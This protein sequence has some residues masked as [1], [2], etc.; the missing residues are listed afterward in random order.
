QFK[1]A[2]IQNLQ[3]KIKNAQTIGSVR[4]FSVR[5]EFPSEWAKFQ[6]VSIGGT[7][8][9]APLLLTLLPEHYP[10]WAKNI[11]GSKP[12]KE[13]GLFAELDDGK[14]TV[15]LYDKPDPTAS[16]VKTDTL[17]QDPLLGNLLT[18]RLS[19]ISCPAAVTDAT[20]PPLT[21]YFDNNSM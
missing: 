1:T 3:T 5:H 7:T 13:V 21:L 10:F 18:G 14:T 12:L 8:P 9:T 20:H 19:N 4:L 15:N 11:V 17:S 2:A 16:G 6:S